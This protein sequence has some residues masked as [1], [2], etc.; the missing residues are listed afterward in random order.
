MLL[1]NILWVIYS[2]L[3]G[4]SPY[5]VIPLFF[6]EVPPLILIMLLVLPKEE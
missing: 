5:F 1:S 4:S 6:V 2:G 3:S